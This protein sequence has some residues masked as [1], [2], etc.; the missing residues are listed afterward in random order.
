MTRFLRAYFY[1]LALSLSQFANVLFL[2]GDADESLSGRIGKGL[3]A[4]RWWARPFRLWPAFARHCLASREADEGAASAAQ[5]R[6]F[7]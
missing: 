3:A 4:N 6:E 2:A 1:N 7:P 5:R